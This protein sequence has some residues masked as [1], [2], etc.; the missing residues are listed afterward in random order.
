MQS[1]E[2]RGG[3]MKRQG[4]RRR[5]AS[6][7]P[8]VLAGGAACNAIVGIDDPIV[9]EAP[10][11]HCILNSDCDDSKQVCLFETCS[12]PCAGDVDCEPGEFCLRTDVGNGCVREQTAAC[13]ASR[14][15]PA[16]TDCFDGACLADCSGDASIC[17]EGQRCDADGACRGS[18]TGGSG[19]GGGG[20]GGTNGGAGAGGRAGGSA[21]SPGS[22][23]AGGSGT[24]GLPGAA[25]EGAQAGEGGTAGDGSGGTDTAGSGGD[26]PATECET[27]E[28]RCDEDGLRQT[29]D[30]TGFWGEP[31][32]CPYVCIAGA[33]TGECVPDTNDC[34]PDGVSRLEC[35]AMGVWEV[36]QT[37][38]GVCSGG[39]CAGSC[40][41]G[42][43]QCAAG[44]L[45]L[46]G[47]DGRWGTEED[48]P[49]ICDPVLKDCTGECDPNQ[50]RCSDGK[51]QTCQSDANWNAGTTCPFVCE[52]G[53][54]PGEF[55]CGGECRPGT[56][57][58][59]SNTELA[60]CGTDGDWGNPQTCVNMAC[61]GNPA[62][63]GGECAPGTTACEDASTLLSCGSD[64]EYDSTD[65]AASNRACIA[66]TGGAFGCGGSCAPGNRRCNNNAVE[67]CSAQG[68]YGNP[69]ACTGQA[70]VESG[71]SAAC[72]G[73]CS[74]GSERCANNAVET[75]SA[76]GAYG[77]PQTCT[78]QTCLLSGTDASCQGVCAPNQTNCMTGDAY[79]CNTSGTWGLLADCVPPGQIC[80]GG[81]CVANNP[82]TI[83]FGTALPD[84]ESPADNILYLQKLPV[85]S[86]DV[87]VLVLGMVGRGNNGAFARFALYRDNAGL[88]GAYVAR[89]G[90]VQVLMGPT[91]DVPIP[92][93]TRL[94][95]GTTYW[96]GA[97]FTGGAQ[98]YRRAN[99]AAP[100]I[101]RY[102]LT[103]GN[104]FPDPVSGGTQLT[105]LEWN[106]YVTV[107]NVAQ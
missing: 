82:Y 9:V 20:K 43:R 63:C 83:G 80:Q 96:V 23:G 90:D 21:G 84:P 56:T 62:A 52:A 6:W 15:C 22:G 24:A 49:F 93:A 70:C 98:T 107:R 4:V 103:Y 16:G 65:C 14:P 102:A 11:E 26:G 54:N 81:A 86:V 17:L 57:E 106:F 38:S 31:E 99:S 71:S 100:P 30:G 60:T 27:N 87:D 64:G 105:G 68:S 39:A 95:A 47:Q 101:R 76:Q 50:L 74:P 97:V 66:T 32:E 8:L 85:L 41:P 51:L 44:I 10:R 46:C 42:T 19:A 89:T 36:V 61:R 25:G 88:P 94:T 5:P 18:G 2:A 55:R 28:T 34:D 67:T 35:S 92:L 1:P 91:E 75:C 13:D 37:C 69:S 79:R 53:D 104:T 7:L 72:Q 77:N 78:N 33:C 73:N 29:C 59:R 58:C 48:C 3:L 45:Q 12:P 40:S